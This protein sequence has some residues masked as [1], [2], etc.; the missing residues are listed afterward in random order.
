MN[1]QTGDSAAEQL[2]FIL[3]SSFRNQAWPCEQVPY[4]MFF[5][6]WVSFMLP[7]YDFTWYLMFDTEALL[8][9][10]S[11]S[12]GS[13]L[14]T[15]PVV[16]RSEHPECLPSPLQVGEMESRLLLAFQDHLC[17]VCCKSLVTVH[18]ILSAGEWS[19]FYLQN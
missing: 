5:S 19:D 13:S 11:S 9:L 17:M 15:S 8:L 6:V 4:G 10:A 2:S 18:Q 16:P 1:A 14:Q 3:S 12:S 7:R